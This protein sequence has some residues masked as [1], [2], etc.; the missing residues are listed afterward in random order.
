MEAL[1]SIALIEA[2]S[3]QR[4]NKSRVFAHKRVES[5]SGRANQE[6]RILEEISGY[7]TIQCARTD[8]FL[9]II[10]GQPDNGIGVTCSSNAKDSDHQLWELERASR[11]GHEIKSIIGLWRLELLDRL[12]EP[13]GDNV[14]YFVLPHTLRTTIWEGTKLARQSV[15]NGTFDYDDFLIKMKDAVNTWAR[16]RLRLDGYSVLFGL[17]YGET[18][19]G[20]KAYNWYLSPDM[21]ALVFFDAQTNR[22]YT[23]R[24]LDDFGFKPNFML[25]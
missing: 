15:R 16:D 2:P 14:Q 21:T 20:P 24:S 12:V 6:W 18:R 5:G 1:I 10:D 17:I 13:Y 23:I 7:Y 19:R 8:T 22:E 9:E 3:R 4:E 11:S 25:F